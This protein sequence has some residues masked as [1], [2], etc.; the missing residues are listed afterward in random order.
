MA[1]QDYQSNSNCYELWSN[2]MNDNTHFFR[3]L[4]C[5]LFCAPVALAMAGEINIRRYQL[6]DHG[7]IQL[8][9]PTL[10]KD[11]IQQPP[12]RL[13]PTITF[14]QK[15]GASFDVLITPIWPAKKDMPLTEEEGIRQLVL[16]GA[17]LAQPQSVEEKIELK[18]LDGSSG[19][20]YYFSVT[21]RAPGPGEYKYM[22]QGMVRVS[23]LVVT[24]TILTN[25]GQGNIV[26]D[27][28]AML[29][30]AV[31]VDEGAI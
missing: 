15:A 22:T 1:S 6:P 21:D 28:I 9:V 10:W 13:P 5:S 24:F 26:T 20:G 19:P 25:D 18:K 7:S 2:E 31:H 30:S 12:N 29:K 17:E 16:Q 4:M 3:A 27:A 8:K 11:E 23:N 14:K